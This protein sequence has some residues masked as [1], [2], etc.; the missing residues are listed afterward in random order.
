[1]RTATNYPKKTN[2]L[3]WTLQVLLAA[4][5]LFAG[6]MKL[7][8][9]IEAMTQQTPLPGAFLRFIGIAEVLGGLGLILPGITKIQTRLTPLAAAGLVII[10]IGATVMAFSLGGASMAAMPFVTGLIATY[11]AYG[12]SRVVPHGPWPPP[13][14]SRRAAEPFSVIQKRRRASFEALLIL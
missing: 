14:Q 10:M 6:V 11:I 12:R 2:M 1:M 8:M 13:V 9:P 7:V 5:F 4:L 3:L